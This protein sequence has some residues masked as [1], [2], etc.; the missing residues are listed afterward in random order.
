MGG[1]KW[2]L[3]LNWSQKGEYISNEEVNYYRLIVSQ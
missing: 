3:A 2:L 1:K